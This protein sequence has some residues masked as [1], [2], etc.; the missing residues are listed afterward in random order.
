MQRSE[1]TRIHH[2]VFNSS[3]GP[4]VRNCSK[5]VWLRG[6]EEEA[7]KIWALRKGMK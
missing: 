5:S 4:N 7:R 6:V 1:G 3:S 2:S